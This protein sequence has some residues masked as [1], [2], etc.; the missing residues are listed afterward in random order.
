MLFVLAFCFS[1]L[2]AL[3]PE[4]QLKEIVNVAHHYDVQAS[5]DTQKAIAVSN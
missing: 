3:I 1:C 5:T 2:P 4:K